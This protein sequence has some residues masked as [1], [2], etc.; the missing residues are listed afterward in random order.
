[1]RFTYL[2]DS[3]AETTRDLR[4][5]MV[6]GV[7]ATEAV[8][9]VGRLGEHGARGVLPEGPLCCGTCTARPVWCMGTLRARTC[10]LT[11]T[12][13]LAAQKL[14]DFDEARLVPN[15]GGPHETP[16]AS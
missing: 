2:G 6:T 11:A 7:T 9:K 13:S 12:R 10:S 14:A 8:V 5:E 1:M 16:V 15:A 3:G 4:M